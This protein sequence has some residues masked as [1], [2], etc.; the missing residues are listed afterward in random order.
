MST[1]LETAVTGLAVISLAAIGHATY[2]VRKYAPK[3]RGQ[4]AGRP[5]NTGGQP[6]ARPAGAP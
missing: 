4:A 5:G 1:A 2:V 3:P 6:P